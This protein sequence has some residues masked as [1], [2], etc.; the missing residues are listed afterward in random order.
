MARERLVEGEADGTVLGL[1]GLIFLYIG[2]FRLLTDVAGLPVWATFLIY[3]GAHLLTA[4]GLLA[5]GKGMI[6]GRDDDGDDE[7]GRGAS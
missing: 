1:V 3:A 6:T 5:C 7:T 4:I 2:V